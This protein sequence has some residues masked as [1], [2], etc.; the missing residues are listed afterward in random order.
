MSLAQK[1][2]LSSITSLFGAALAL[3]GLVSAIVESSTV[4][5]LVAE[6]NS[7]K[8]AAALCYDIVGGGRS[9]RGSTALGWADAMLDVVGELL[10]GAD[11]TSAETER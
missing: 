11:L 8:V 10:T 2:A 6:A 9:R 4:G 5:L 1:R 3:G 7:G